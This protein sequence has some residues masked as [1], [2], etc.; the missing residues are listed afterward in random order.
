M[1]K[2]TW[3]VK[4]KVFV[5]AFCISAFYTSMPVK[6]NELFSFGVNVRPDQRSVDRLVAA[7]ERLADA[8]AGV[9][10]QLGAEIRSIITQL[11]SERD[12]T[13]DQLDETSKR[14]FQSAQIILSQL[15]REVGDQID[16]STASIYELLSLLAGRE[17]RIINRSGFVY[18]SANS[19]QFARPFIL[20]QRGTMEYVV[21]GAN[22]VHRRGSYA[23]FPRIRSIGSAIQR[24][25]PAVSSTTFLHRA[26]IEF[27]EFDYERWCSNL[28]VQ[29]EGTPSVARSASIVIE[30]PV[31]PSR[32]QSWIGLDRFFEPTYVRFPADHQFWPGF[33]GC[34][35]ISVLNLRQVQQTRPDPVIGTVSVASPGNDPGERTRLCP[36]HGLNA[37]P[38]APANDTTYLF[39]IAAYAEG[40]WQYWTNIQQLICNDRSPRAS[41]HPLR[42]H[43][44]PPGD[45]SWSGSGIYGPLGE[46]PTV[47]NVRAVADA[48]SLGGRSGFR[49]SQTEVIISATPARLVNVWDSEP[50][51]S[52]WI[53]LPANHEI[54]INVEEVVSNVIERNIL[55]EI[56]YPNGMRARFDGASRGNEFVRIESNVSQS[57]RNRERL[58]FVLRSAQ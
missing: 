10:P 23:F 57:T 47:I 36:N 17:P 45:G 55:I 3:K 24:E 48:V 52:S 32:W 20:S 40:G 25:N 21:L 34:V 8:L 56:V 6:A 4:T 49:A 29:P 35:R 39:D 58:R 50:L 26:T 27:E 51:L 12:K 37:C 5:A 38:R 2:K 33:L 22:L 15:S 41:Q 7:L 9:I 18:R 54:S 11:A 28:G 16:I 53:P 14:A 1:A 19:Y 44:S 31:P 13:F 42:R 46:R 43:C 30:A